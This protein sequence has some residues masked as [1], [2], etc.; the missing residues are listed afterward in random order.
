[1]KRLIRPAR[2]VGMSTTEQFSS[3]LDQR[4]D[5]MLKEAK[6]EIRDRVRLARVHL[7]IKEY[8]RHLARG[9]VPIDF[10]VWYLFDAYGVFAK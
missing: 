1:M 8:D 9:V 2:K 5:D 3:S 7:A 4:L 10:D 6:A